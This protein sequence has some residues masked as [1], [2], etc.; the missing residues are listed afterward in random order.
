MIG[1]TAG[2]TG[3][4]YAGTRPPFM[5]GAQRERKIGEVL[6]RIIPF[7]LAGSRSYKAIQMQSCRTRRRI[8]ITAEQIGVNIR[9]D[10]RIETAVTLGRGVASEDTATPPPDHARYRRA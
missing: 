6:I 2:K 1:S 3:E 9:S 8:A 4:G 5:R 7:E 10:E